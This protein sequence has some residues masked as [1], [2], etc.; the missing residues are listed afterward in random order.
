MIKV[1]KQYAI[2]KDM[3]DNCI[4]AINYNDLEGF[5]VNPK[6]QIQYDGIVVN[7]LV[8]INQ[9]FIQKVLKKK[10]KRK[11][12]MY[13]QMIMYLLNEEGETGETIEEALND[14]SRYRDIIRY[15]YQKYLDEKYISLLL[16]KVNLLEYE[17]RQRLAYV[18]EAE[19]SKGGKS[20]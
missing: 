2:K 12:D 14:L 11:L 5:K 6:N 19:N 17:L 7:Q 10:I 13:L 9:S 16:Q 4:I 3:Y 15:K 1:L 18:V 8:L 20:R